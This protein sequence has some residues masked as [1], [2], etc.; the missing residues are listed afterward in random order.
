MELTHNCFL[1]LMS[2]FSKILISLF[3]LDFLWRVSEKYKLVQLT[4]K[5]KIKRTVSYSADLVLDLK[6][7]YTRWCFWLLHTSAQ[8]LTHRYPSVT[9]SSVPLS[10]NGTLQVTVSFYWCVIWYRLAGTRVKK[11]RG[12]GSGWADTVFRDKHSHTHADTGDESSVP[13]YLLLD[14]NIYL[15]PL[16][17]TWGI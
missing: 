2:C 11:V 15:S 8:M 14:L 10:S 16:T 3:V 17:S 4:R 12:E 9:R 6:L 7:C 5:T 1:R 13:S